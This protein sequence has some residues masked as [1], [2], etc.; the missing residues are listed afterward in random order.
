MNVL[1]KPSYFLLKKFD[2]TNTYAQ[3]Y[4]CIQLPELLISNILYA[5]LGYIY[6]NVERMDIYL[7]V[8]LFI[9]GVYNFSKNQEATSKF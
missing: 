7:R 8:G 2:L 3:K 4:T 9:P 5:Y 1:V 6:I